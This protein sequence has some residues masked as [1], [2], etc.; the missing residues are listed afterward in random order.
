MDMPDTEWR[1]PL[2]CLKLQVI[3]RK[4]AT[5]YMALLR[6]ITCEDK[7][8]YDS[9]PPCIMCRLKRAINYRALLRKITYEDKASYDSRPLCIMCRLKRD[10]NILSLLYVPFRVVMFFHTEDISATRPIYMCD[11]THSYFFIL[12]YYTIHDFPT[13][14][15]YSIH[16]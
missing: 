15:P 7:A 3:F 4:R 12:H 2:G 9:T 16:A 5:N 10:G 11:K 13:S 14:Y 8:S 6:K 1:T